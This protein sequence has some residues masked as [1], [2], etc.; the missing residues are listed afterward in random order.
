MTW[1]NYELFDLLFVTSLINV[2]V[3]SSTLCSPHTCHVLGT[4]KAVWPV[5]Q[6]WENLPFSKYLSVQTVTLSFAL[7]H[8][9]IKLHRDNLVWI[10]YYLFT[11]KWDFPPQ[12]HRH[13]NMIFMYIFCILQSCCIGFNFSLSSNNL[14]HTNT[15]PPERSRPNHCL[16]WPSR[17]ITP[18]CD[19]LGTFSKKLTLWKTCL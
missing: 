18:P 5:G 13:T 15:R 1:P 14:S 8:K 19:A 7:P 16:S 11:S 4:S 17:V 6:I 3:H 9:S 12:I 2:Q 10:I